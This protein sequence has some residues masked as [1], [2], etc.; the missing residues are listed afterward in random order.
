MGESELFSGFGRNKDL[1][2]LFAGDAQFADDFALH[3]LALAALGGALKGDVLTFE[4]LF[5]H[6]LIPQTHF[7]G[8]FFVGD[9]QSPVFDGNG[10]FTYPWKLKPGTLVLT[11]NSNLVNLLKLMAC[12]LGRRGEAFWEWEGRAVRRAAKQTVF[13]NMGKVSSLAKLHTNA[14]SIGPMGEK[15]QR[16]NWPFWGKMLYLWGNMVKS[17]DFVSH[18]GVSRLTVGIEKESI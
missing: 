16:H 14:T 13:K 9:D 6:M 12:N 17:H 18:R 11:K 3:F 2:F 7:R 1:F 4:N 8:D 10:F 5:V 15:K